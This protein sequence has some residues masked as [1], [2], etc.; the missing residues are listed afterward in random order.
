M[1]TNVDT[2]RHLCLINELETSIGFLKR[3]IG[4]LQSLDRVNDFCEAPIFLL[5]FGLEKFLKSIM[6]IVYWEDLEILEKY[7]KKWVKRNGHNLENLL[8]AVIDI[9]EEK[10][11]SSKRPVGKEDLDFIIDNP[12]LN[13]LIAVLSNFS[14]GGRYYNLDIIMDRKSK[15]SDPKKGWE[16]IENEIFFRRE[17]L[18][19][20]LTDDLSYNHISEI[21]KE[22]VVILETFLRAISR[23]F[24]LAD[25]GPL[26]KKMS[27]IVYDFLVLSDEEIGKRDY[28]NFQRHPK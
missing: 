21:I 27:S 6:V 22:I 25:I 4:E 20:R 28:N 13:H 11:Y 24:T 26:G 3:G 23:F 19:R 17:D 18:Q 8:K 5:S 12:D 15:F 7:H 1:V 14:Q 16:K 10:K 2:L 9:V